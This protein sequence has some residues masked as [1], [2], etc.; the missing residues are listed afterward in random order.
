MVIKGGVLRGTVQGGVGVDT[1]HGLDLISGNLGLLLSC[2]Q[3]CREIIQDFVGKIT[4]GHFLRIGGKV[5]FG[6]VGNVG[7]KLA[8]GD[9]A[10]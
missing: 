9:S 10:S 5:W 6:N 3:F 4:S 8:T 1:L 7:Q 2:F